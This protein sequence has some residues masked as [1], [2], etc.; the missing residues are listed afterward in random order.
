MAT[1]WPK[2]QWSVFQQQADKTYF[3]VVIGQNLAEDEAEAL[4]K[5]AVQAGLPRDTYIKKVL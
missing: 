3:L 5:R 2:F 4:R 1:K